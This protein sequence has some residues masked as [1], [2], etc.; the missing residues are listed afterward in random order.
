MGTGNMAAAGVGTNGEAPIEAADQQN[1][2]AKLMLR[3][4][5]LENYIFPS[6]ILRSELLN[7]FFPNGWRL[8]SGTGPERSSSSSKSGVAGLPNHKAR[9]PGMPDRA[10]LQ[11]TSF[12]RHSG[13]FRI[14]K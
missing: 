1:E 11:N 5:N 2:N 10:V 3:F 12:L 7:V 6:D 4:R 13:G 9:Q 14:K 8:D